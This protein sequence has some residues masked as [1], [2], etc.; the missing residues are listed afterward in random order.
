MPYKFRYLEKIIG[1]FIVFAFLILIIS[2]IFIAKGKKL[3]VKKEYYYT[4][5]N[6]AEALSVGMPVKFKGL[7]IG[8]VKSIKLNNENKIIVKFYILKEYANRVKKDSIIKV[9]APLIGSKNLVIT[10][11]R[12]DSPVAEKNNFLYSI[13]TEKG[14]LLLAEQL[15][16]EPQTPT[17]LIIQNVQILTAEL[18]DPNGPLIK[19][20]KNLQKFSANFANSFDQ[21]AINNTIKMLEETAKN[22]R[23]LSRSLKENPL[24]RGGKEKIKSSSKNRRR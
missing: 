6:S 21:T 4:V 23:D 5:F 15:K 12:K 1:I 8:A 19:T 11:G 24:L 22:L 14:R 20:L 3:W 16:K 13:D 17:D 18:S 2:I 9:N 10:E 7:S